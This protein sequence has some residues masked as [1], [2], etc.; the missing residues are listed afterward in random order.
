M[1][2]MDTT[3][4]IHNLT[5]NEIIA[6]VSVTPMN[7]ELYLEEKE[8][9]A[10]SQNIQESITAKKADLNSLKSD[11]KKFISGS[12]KRQL[13]TSYNKAN[14]KSV[15]NKSLYSPSNSRSLKIKKNSISLNSLENILGTGNSI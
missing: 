10:I 8:N 13:S 4:N 14:G 6:K 9:K 5:S 3:N 15:N 2:N 7:I 11:L 1:M 12:S